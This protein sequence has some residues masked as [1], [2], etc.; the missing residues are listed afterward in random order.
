[1]VL[2]L[3]KKDWKVMGLLTFAA[4][5]AILIVLGGVAVQS[6]L[7]NSGFITRYFTEPGVEWSARHSIKALMVGQLFIVAGLGICWLLWKK[8]HWLD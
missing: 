3:S 1:M 7:E 2:G 6:A 5:A 8:H 4:I